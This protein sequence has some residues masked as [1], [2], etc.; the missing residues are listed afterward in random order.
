V[1]RYPSVIGGSTPSKTRAQLEAENRLLRAD[2]A[3]LRLTRNVEHAASVA[4][5]AIKVG[6]LVWIASYAAQIAAVLAGQTTEANILFKIL[7]DLRV[8]TALAWA[9]GLSGIGYGWRQRKLR[10]DAV[11]RLAERVARRERELDPRRTS[12]KLTV[13]GD[14][15]PEDR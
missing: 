5:M 11:E 14:T 3:R 6:G 7:G 10:R 9:A 4:I 15:S 8:S 1:A 13:R 12:S 2:L